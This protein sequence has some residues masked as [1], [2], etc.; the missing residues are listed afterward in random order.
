MQFLRPLISLFLVIGLMPPVSLSQGVSGF[1]DIKNTPYQQSIEFL[2]ERGIVKGYPDGTFRQ[3]QS[4][5]RAEMLKILMESQSV[6]LK[7]TLTNCFQ[8]VQ[9]QWFAPYVCNAK[10]TGLVKGYAD[11]SFH[12]GEPIN[13]AEG[14][15]VGLD[16]FDQSV[17]SIK[18]G[19]WFQPYVEFAHQHNLFSKF[20]YLPARSMT[21]GEL[22]FLMHQLILNQEGTKKL[23]AERKN[24]SAG[25]GVTPPAGQP[26]HSTIGGRERTYITSIPKGYNKDVPVKLVF[27]FHGRT[28]SN[29]MVRGYY[30]VEEASKGAAIVVYPSGIDAGNG[31]RSWSDPG[32]PPSKLRDYALF[33]QLLKEFSSNY[34][35]DL[36]EVYVVGHSLGAWFVNS[37]ACFRGDVIRGVG[38]LGGGTSSGQCTGPVAAMIWHNPKD[39]LVPFA[40]G[41]RARDQYIKQNACST[42]SVPVEPHEGNCVEYQGCANDAPLVWCPHRVDTDFRGS[43]YPHTW[44]NFTGKDM[45]AFFESLK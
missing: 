15:K 18:E 10:Q 1:S 41:I 8:D 6:P 28:N 16:I 26:N 13:M 27:A 23:A 45:W 17:V 37:L 11:G 32:D 19:D 24:W 44:P 33:D 36:D 30:K 31:G 34:C 12:P 40:D 29:A 2:A 4:V 43:Y 7:E 3:N 35:V 21:R 5:N 22:S 9:G 14:L 25:C 20:S 39:N 38:S 42:K